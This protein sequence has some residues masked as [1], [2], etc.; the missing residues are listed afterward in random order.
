MRNKKS[1]RCIEELFKIA[2]ITG[3]NSDVGIQSRKEAVQNWIDR[4]VMEYNHDQPYIK[5]N[6][7][8]EEK[9]FI[10]EYSKFVIINELM[11]E[12]VNIEDDKKR[13]KMIVRAIKTQ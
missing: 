4:W 13:L 11:E 1:D 10:K 8:E 5:T 9:E 12:C 6:F 2:E 3:I 7:S